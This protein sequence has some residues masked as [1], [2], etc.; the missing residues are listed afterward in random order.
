MQDRY[1]LGGVVT[2]QGT[3]QA[4]GYQ[5]VLA[6]PAGGGGAPSDGVWLTG[7]VAVQ[8]H[9]LPSPVPS[10]RAAEPQAWQTWPRWVWPGLIIWLF[11][12]GAVCGL[13][14][15]ALLRGG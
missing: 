2:E 12:L 11:S 15:A 9:M 7:L 3:E 10:Q 8:G 1:D 6:V 4:I 5:P 13:V 14:V